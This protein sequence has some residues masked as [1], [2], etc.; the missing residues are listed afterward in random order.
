MEYKCITWQKAFNRDMSICISNL[1]F[2]A[3]FDAKLII[4]AVLMVVCTKNSFQN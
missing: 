4:N 3:T 1:A 2:D